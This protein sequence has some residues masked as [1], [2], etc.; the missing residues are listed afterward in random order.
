MTARSAASPLAATASK[1]SKGCRQGC[2]TC[3][4]A[5]GA[6]PAPLA[7][8][9]C[10]SRP[11][12]KV[13]PWHPLPSRTPPVKRLRIRS[14][15][16]IE[17]AS[18]FDDVLLEPAASA[19][20][21]NQTDTRT[22]LTRAIELDIP[23]VAAAMDTVTEA[24]MAIAMAQAGGIGVIHKNLDARGAGQRGAQ[25]QEVRIRHGGEPGHHPSRPDPGRRAGAD[26][27]APAS[28]ASRWSS[29]AAASWSAS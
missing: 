18:A 17:E 11:V 10:R 16:I 20:L 13:P 8:A 2:G 12:R 3:R 9:M 29:A 27:A 28:P 22:R 7:G 23:L 19:V 15:L 24:P 6:I 25:G 5:I 1:G 4:F 21:P 26:G 14:S